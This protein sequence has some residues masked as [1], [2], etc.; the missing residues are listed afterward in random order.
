MDVTGEWLL[1]RHLEGNSMS[2]KR[3]A[4]AAY[5][6]QF[7]TQGCLGCCNFERVGRFDNA[8]LVLDHPVAEYA[9]FAY[10]RF[11]AIRVDGEDMLLPATFV[12]A[13]QGAY[14]RR[15]DAPQMWRNALGYYAFRRREK[16]MPAEEP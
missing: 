15:E 10:D 13:F 8:V 14:E 3:K 1:L 7:R 5:A 6:V 16:L 11:Y 9:P 2:I 12:D 4:G